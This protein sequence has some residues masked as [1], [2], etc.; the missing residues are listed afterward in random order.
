MSSGADPRIDRWIA[1]DRPWR[2]ELARLREIILSEG[3]NESLKWRQPCYGAFGTNIAIL[4]AMSD[5]VAVSFLKGVLLDD[6]EGRL[7]APGPNSRSARYMRFRS[8]KQI[9]EETETFSGFLRQAIENAKQGRVVAFPSDDFD[10]PPELSDALDDDTR[11]SAAWGELTP[12]RRRGWVL[13]IAGAKR[14]E[15]RAAR[16]ERARPSILAGKGPHDR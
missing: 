13:A 2:A 15:T 10:L 8:M 6:P 7:E 14:P 1:K 5:S 11:F 3:L 12:G 16:V 4:A 9:A